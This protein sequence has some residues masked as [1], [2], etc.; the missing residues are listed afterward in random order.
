M[1]DLF[2]TVMAALAQPRKGIAMYQ[3]HKYSEASRRM[4]QQGLIGAQKF[5]VCNSLLEHAVLAS[6]CKPKALVDMCELAVPPFRNMWI[7]WDEKRRMELLRHHGT[8]LGY[9]DD[10]F[11]WTPDTWADEVGYHIWDDPPMPHFCYSQYSLNEGQILVPPMS[12]SMVN[13]GDMDARNSDHYTTA[14]KVVPPTLEEVRR[15]QRRFGKV[16]LSSPY[17]EKHKGDASLE[18]LYYRMNPSISNAGNMILPREIAR[19]PE[20]RM[21]MADQSAKAYAGDMRFLIA[22]LALVNY[23]HTIIERKV[24]MGPTRIAYGRRVPRNEL[25]VLEIDL[26]KPRGTT[27]YERMFKGGG[28]KKRRHV[29]RGHWRRYRRKDGTVTTQWIKEQWVGSAE[30]GTITHDYELKSK[31]TK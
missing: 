17:A 4:C 20:M 19:D 16:L 18:T 24:E 15:Q 13:E 27:R 7:E 11:E 6:F 26:P 22:V 28:G 25:R 5:T 14:G 30:V 23:P 3:S 21:Q 31:G 2:N 1:S 8:K 29:R 12:F 9:F 10:G